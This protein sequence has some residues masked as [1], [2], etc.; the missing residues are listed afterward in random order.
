MLIWLLWQGSVWRERVRSGPIVAT[1][2]PLSG[3]GTDQCQHQATLLVTRSLEQHGHEATAAQ[4]GGVDMSVSLDSGMMPSNQSKVWNGAFAAKA[5]SLW[6]LLLFFCSNSIKHEIYLLFTTSNKN[7]QVCFAIYVLISNMPTTHNAIVTNTSWHLV[8]LSLAPLH[9]LHSAF[10][11]RPAQ[12][13]QIFYLLFYLTENST[14]RHSFQLYCF[15]P[16]FTGRLCGAG[17][18]FAE[19]FKCSA[20]MLAACSVLAFMQSEL[21]AGAASA[22][23]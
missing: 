4:I 1:F 10:H 18:G 22:L 6:T 7:V 23:W 16:V 13:K 14:P 11:P 20:R 17:G 15:Q 2:R 21:G 19:I 8:S 12:H 9:F 5:H 3:Q